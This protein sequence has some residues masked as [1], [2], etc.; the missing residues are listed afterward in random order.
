VTLDSELTYKVHISRLILKANCRL[1]KLHPELNKSSVINIILA[2]GFCTSFLRS[3][4]TYPFPHWSYAD[5]THANELQ[6]FLNND[7]GIITKFRSVTPIK[8]LYEKTG[9]NSIWN[10][11]EFFDQNKD[12]I[13]VPFIR[14]AMKL[15]VVIIVGYHCYQLH[16]KCYPISFSQD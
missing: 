11:E 2:S 9:I 13:I 3:I 10:K 4:L 6:T 5:E 14:S 15:N 12:H 1:R 8:I 16:A 7:L